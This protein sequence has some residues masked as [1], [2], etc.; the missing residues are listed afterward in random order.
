[1]SRE[2]GFLQLRRGVFRH[3][4]DGCLNPL[5]ALC[6][7]YMLTQADTRSG[8]WKGGAG[9][10]AGELSIPTRT[11][12]RVLERLSGRYIK[13][14]PVPGQHKCYPVLLHRFL[15]TDGEHRG[16]QL[17]ALDSASP[18]NLRYFTN[19]QNGEHV[20]QH[21]ATQK[22]LETREKKRKKNPAAKSAP[23]ADPRF[24]SFYDFAYE[25]YRTRNVQPPVWGGKDR[26]NL[27]Q[28][29][30]EQPHVVSEEWQRRFWAYLGSTEKF[31]RTQGGS[32]AYFV[33]RFDVFRD[34][35]VLDGTMTG[36]TDGK[37]VGKFES[38]EER[39]R[40]ESAEAI[41]AFRGNL[42]ELDEKVGGN[43]PGSRRN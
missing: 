28:F 31:I 25:A 2:N 13:R 33:T 7:I 32:L 26:K 29:L 24:K 43:L 6:F 14:F 18:A 1:V 37:R 30:A 20:V 40:R 17:N 3:V 38:F 12:R 22:K 42:E 36:G 15:I 41:A 27:E 16:E 19:E 21:V 39:R 8:V 11:A 10:L 34:G 35:P 23:P 5:Q 4:R 9:A